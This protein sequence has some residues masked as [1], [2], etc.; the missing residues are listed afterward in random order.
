MDLAVQLCAYLVGL[1]LEVLTIAAM[2]H[3]GFK[4]Y[5]F[6]FAYL[7]TFFLTTVAEMP[8][9][10]AYYYLRLILPLPNARV[11]QAAEEYAWWYWRDEA[12]LQILVF[13]VV[14]SLIYYATARLAARRIVRV[15]LIVGAVA[16]A[17]VSFL[18]HYQNPAPHVSYGLWA[19]AWTRDLRVCAAVLDLALWAILIAAR[20]KDSRLLMLTCALGIM[21]AGEAV[22]ESL[23]NLASSFVSHHRGHILSDAGGLLVL[24]SDLGFLYI[25]WRAFRTPKP[26]PNEAALRLHHS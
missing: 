23:R 10:V 3:D 21:F 20:E 9:S 16:F 17:L 22:G 15:G 6:V 7:I 12:V 13:A 5:P 14:I 4:R 2:L 19:T 11:D 1:P 8:S 24:I 26:P 25:W 18:V